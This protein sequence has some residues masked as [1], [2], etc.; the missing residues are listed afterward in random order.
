MA[1]MRQLQDDS[2]LDQRMTP[3]S[4][5]PRTGRK[6]ITPYEDKIHTCVIGK[7]I[8]PPRYLN[9][10]RTL[11]ELN[12]AVTRTAQDTDFAW[13][14]SRLDFN[15]TSHDEPSD[16]AVP[17]WKGFNVNIKLSE[18]EASL[19]SRSTPHTIGYCQT[20]HKAPDHSVIYTFLCR[21]IEMTDRVMD[22]DHGK[23]TC[24]VP[25]VVDMGI[26]MKAI[27]VI[28]SKRE[29]NPSMNRIV[30]HQGP[31]HTSMRF[32]ACPGFLFGSAGLRDIF[33]ESGILAE[34]SVDKVLQGEHWER[35]FYAYTLV[36][37]AFERLR[38]EAFVQQ[39][40]EKESLEELKGEVDRLRHNMSAESQVALTSSSSFRKIVSSYSNY[41][42]TLGPNGRFWSMYLDMIDN[43]LRHVRASRT[44]DWL[45][46][47]NSE[48]EMLLYKSLCK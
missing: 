30:L 8:E 22:W 35:G 44:G 26:W 39:L 42:S 14:L 28:L 31:F 48:V 18:V 27:E 4:M 29:S 43:M 45:L 12:P 10:S 40:K 47:L 9:A 38:F 7:R 1:Q 19:E 24:S 46:S 2:D 11:V 21:S 17:G 15:L 13:K 32:M 37:E 6:S 41:I 25:V 5:Q 16:Q 3:S 34:G 36:A 33:I 23:G 20:I